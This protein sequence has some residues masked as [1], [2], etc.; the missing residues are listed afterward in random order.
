MEYDFKLSEQI[1]SRQMNWKEN[2]LEK[3]AN[4][5]IGLGIG[6]VGAKISQTPCF[7]IGATY[8]NNIGIG[9][10]AAMDGVV[11][12]GRDV[13]NSLRYNLNP[14]ATIIK[15]STNDTVLAIGTIAGY[16]IGKLEEAIAPFFSK[17]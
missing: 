11:I 16:T 4:L 6:Y 10:S 13:Y 5:T 15:E 7:E 12:A 14:S 8:G 2:A 1:R 17:L 9:V 3:F